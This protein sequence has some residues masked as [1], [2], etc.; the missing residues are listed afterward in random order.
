MNETKR[1]VLLASGI[2]LM[3]AATLLLSRAKKPGLDWNE[4]D[5]WRAHRD[6]FMQWL[7]DHGR[8]SNGD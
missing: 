1:I 4:I 6:D 2:V 3:V 8:L 7:R 5:E